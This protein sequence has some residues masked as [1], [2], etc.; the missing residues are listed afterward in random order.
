MKGQEIKELVK[1]RYGKVA[2]KNHSCCDFGSVHNQEI[3]FTER[4]SKKIGYTDEDIGSVPE[5]SNLGLG[6]GNPI[7]L[8]SLKEGDV[9]LDLGKGH[10]ISTLWLYQCGIQHEFRSAHAPDMVEL[11]VYRPVRC[12][13][14]RDRLFFARRESES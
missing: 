5:E 14:R 9:V 12:R 3:D 2:S 7:A 13:V 10:G 8:A 11:K 4:I 1:E 6:C